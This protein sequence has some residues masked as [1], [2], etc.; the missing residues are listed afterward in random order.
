LTDAAGRD[1]L[2]SPAMQIAVEAVADLLVSYG[3]DARSRSALR[4]CFRHAGPEAGL[5]RGEAMA[6][7]MADSDPDITADKDALVRFLDV[8]ASLPEADFAV[9]WLEDLLAAWQELR[10]AGCAVDLPLRAARALVSQAG[11]E[12]LAGR[13]A[14]SALE[15]EILTS[16]SAGAMCAAEIIAL[17]ARRS[18][19]AAAIDDVTLPQHGHALEQQLSAALA[20]SAGQ[21][22]GPM[23][24]LLS[25]HLR[26]GAST[27]TLDI[28][29]RDAIIEATID[30]LRGVMRQRDIIVRT[31]LHSCAVILPGLHSAA[32]VRLAA[33][34]VMQAL[35]LPFA[36]RGMV[37]RA[38]FAIGAVWS[39]DH[40]SGAEEL[41]R[42]V[43]L[44][45]ESSLR[46]E[47]PV[48]FFD[49]D[50][51][52]EARRQASAEREFLAALDNGQLTIHVQPQIDLRTWRCIGGELLLRWTD[53]QGFNVP[54]WQIPEIAMRL[55]AGPQL[56][57][58]LVFGACRTMAELA[59]VGVEI[60]LS[61][62]LMARDLMDHELPMLV[63]QAIDFWR[64]PP[65]RLTFELVESAM[66]GDPTAGADVMERLIKLGVSTSIDDFGIGYSSILYLRQLPLQELKIDRVFVDAMAKSK[67]DREIVAALVRLSHGLELQVVA[68]GVENEETANLL[69]EM[70]CDRGQGYWIGRAMPAADLP[71]WLADWNR[72]MGLSG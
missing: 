53:S 3:L 51:L 5:N 1:D 50:L 14:L 28:E 8:F 72:R 2:A 19:K 27:L 10:T 4:A 54:P 34:K 46:T 6:E 70:G 41:V 62:N 18:A 32:Q 47:K 56:T 43:G 29:Q 66:L 24:G 69:R 36:V 37:L 64:V 21:G 7:S 42:C 65:D 49:D 33:R 58:W 25:L 20:Q 68:E 22:I 48:V 55:G 71:A 52:V 26:V 16:L 45:V 9:E 17:E 59:R 12:L 38:V 30:R 61:I 13:A 60:G 57:R 15:V 67:E 63:E 44:A 31:D 35:E 23:V 39:P 11:R 40:G